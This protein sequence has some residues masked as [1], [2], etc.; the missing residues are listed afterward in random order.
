MRYSSVSLTWPSWMAWNT[1]SA[2]ISF[3]MLEGARS[4]SAF[5]S[6]RMLPVEASIRI[7]VGASP[8]KPPS[9]F[10]TPV[11]LW[12]AASSA[13]PQPTETAIRQAIKPRKNP[14][15]ETLH[16][17]NGNIGGAIAKSLSRGAF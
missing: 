1:T 16:G 12:L 3:I 5:F 8:S 4:S 11:M 17:R 15:R 10:L 13:P 6:N 7:A 2:V 9:S 14:P